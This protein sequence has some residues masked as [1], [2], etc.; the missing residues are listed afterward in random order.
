MRARLAQLGPYAGEDVVREVQQ[1]LIEAGDRLWDLEVPEDEGGIT[2][3]LAEAAS[4]DELSTQTEPP[5]GA[6]AIASSTRHPDEV[7]TVPGGG[8]HHSSK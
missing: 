1:A 2:P 7:T 4:E 3:P 6:R 5:N 8:P